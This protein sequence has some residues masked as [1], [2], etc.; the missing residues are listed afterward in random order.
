MAPYS[1]QNGLKVP[2]KKKKKVS[3]SERKRR[4]RAKERALAGKSS[5]EHAP[6]ST[7]VSTKTKNEDSSEITTKMKSA[8]GQQKILVQ[9]INTSSAKADALKL[10]NE[11]SMTSRRVAFVYPKADKQTPGGKSVFYVH[12]KLRK[13]KVATE[14]EGKVNDDEEL[15]KQ[16]D[17]GDES[18]EDILFPARR[19][20]KKETPS[21]KKDKIKQKE[22]ANKKESITLLEKEN[23]V[24]KK[25]KKKELK[26]E[27]RSPKALELE[28]ESYHNE[29]KKDA[30][31]P[32]ERS[33]IKRSRSDSLSDPM[34]SRLSGRTV[35]DAIKDKSG[36]RPRSNSTDGELKLPKRGLCDERMVIRNYKWDLDVFKRAPPRGF[37]NLGNTC[38]LNSTLQCLAYLPTFCQCVATLP[39]GP[40]GGS[41]QKK[42]NGNSGHQIT[43]FLRNLLRKVHGLDGDIKQVPL[44][45]KSIVRSISSL[46]GSHRGYKFRPGRQEDAHEF[47]V[48]LLDAMNN[49]ELKAAG[50]LDVQL[51]SFYLSTASN[52]FMPFMM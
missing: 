12:S 49:G 1:A 8:E 45:P 35:E 4:K 18:I 15:K 17:L 3:K 44:A 30:D 42:K 19:N 25:E 34:K 9:E 10:V 46:G 6:E 33:R 28:E 2:P 51:R 14:E 23:V 47:L 40:N 11:A 39:I 31:Q 50:E 13:A 29:E 37:I 24:Q 43:M 5:D 7:I 21:K 27:I 48:H 20:S 26:A 38:F 16:N 52:N 32:E 41:G 36:R 22:L